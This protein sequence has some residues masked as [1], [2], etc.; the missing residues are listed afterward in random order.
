MCSTDDEILVK[1]AA[2]AASAHGLAELPA[3]LVQSVHR[4][5]VPVS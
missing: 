3:D 4:S 1:V 2:H 5:I